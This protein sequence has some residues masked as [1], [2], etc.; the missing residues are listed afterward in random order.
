MSPENAFSIKFGLFELSAAGTFTIATL[1]MLTVL[2]VG[3]RVFLILWNR[4]S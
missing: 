1:A 2:Y 4:K 3:T